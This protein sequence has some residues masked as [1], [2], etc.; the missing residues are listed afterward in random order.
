MEVVGVSV[1][2]RPALHMIGRAEI[3]N[4]VEMSWIRLL[5]VV[6]TSLAGSCSQTDMTA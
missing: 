2:R 1:T 4:E 5:A 3:V 6:V